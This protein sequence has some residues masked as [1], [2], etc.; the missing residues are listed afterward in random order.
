M[1]AINAIIDYMASITIRRLPERTKRRL[2]LRA[3]RNGHSME[4]EARKLLEAGLADEKIKAPNIG[5]SIRKIF[6]PLGG[7]D[8]K[9][10]PRGPIRASGIR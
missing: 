8:L 7:V 6:A 5:E 2:R 3:A 1:S 4:E 9:I 10:P